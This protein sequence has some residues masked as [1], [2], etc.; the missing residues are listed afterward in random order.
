MVLQRHVDKIFRSQRIDAFYMLSE[1]HY[2]TP[3]YQFFSAFF[4]RFYLSTRNEYFTLTWE[5]WIWFLQYLKD[6]GSTEPFA[7]LLESAPSIDVDN[8]FSDC[9]D[10]LL[11]EHTENVD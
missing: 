10:Y 7:G 9:I 11:K 3:F 1:R 2:R 5:H 8:N 4:S 6:K